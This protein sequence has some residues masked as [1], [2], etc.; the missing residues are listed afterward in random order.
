[1]P[2]RMEVNGSLVA[3]LVFK[4]SDPVSEPANPQDLIDGAP[5]ARSAQRSADSENTPASDP[6]ATPA[7]VPAVAVGGKGWDPALADLADR[8]A[9][10][11]PEQREAL[12]AILAG[13]DG[14]QPDTAGQGQAEGE[15]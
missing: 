5:S 12:A 3:P 10:L 6:A 15:R 11:T 7:A 2:R 4:T 13:G 9:A 14:E 1:M 8:L